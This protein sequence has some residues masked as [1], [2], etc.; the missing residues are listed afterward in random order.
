MPS[1]LP[2]R[3]KRDRQ[4]NNVNAQTTN[5]TQLHSHAVPSALA[6]C[7][8]LAEVIS[9]V[10]DARNGKWD[11]TL[12]AGEVILDH[13]LCLPDGIRLSDNAVKSLARLTD[14]PSTV[15]SWCIDRGYEK[16][17]ADFIGDRL[18]EIAREDQRT[19]RPPTRF[20]TR[21]RRA[22][23]G[24]TQCRALF[25]GQYGVLD[26]HD[27]LSLATR[28][29]ES[30]ELSDVVARRVFHN[31]DDLSVSLLIPDYAVTLPDSDYG[32][33]IEIGNSE[34]DGPFTV[35]G[36]IYR[37]MCGN[38]MLL[39]LREGA[40]YSRRHV[41]RIDF[42]EVLVG[43]KLAVHDAL[44]LG[45]ESIKTHADAWNVRIRNPKRLIAHLG[46]SGRLSREQTSAW[47]KG[48]EATIR[49]PRSPEGTLG[50]VLNGL[51]FA[52][53]TV[54]PWERR[55]M[56]TEAGR[57]IAPSIGLALGDLER[58]WSDLEERARE[59]KSEEVERIAAL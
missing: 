27:A 6:K 11:A 51:T 44:S 52:A 50:A 58:R 24:E 32:V 43:V 39:G 33:G 55:A 48:Y 22:E 8:T 40:E 2:C 29:F 21:F 59:I 18:R 36:F 9:E 47:M 56:E 46:K 28:A 4:V 57:L 45:R 30:A 12:N 26:N 13:S 1:H 25:T 49:E 14:V 10:N 20:F 16:Q 17:V 5:L 34:V 42:D 41:G 38:G 7:R 31:G 35:N 54:A 53:K 19:S 15:T 37:A 3:S 23:S